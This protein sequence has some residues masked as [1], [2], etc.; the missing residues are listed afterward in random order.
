MIQKP[1]DLL[2]FISNIPVLSDGTIPLNTMN[3]SVSTMPSVYTPTFTLS[4]LARMTQDI[5]KNDEIEPVNTE[6][7]PKTIV[8]Q[9]LNSDLA[10]YAPSIYLLLRAVI[11]ESF[12]LLYHI[13]QSSANLQYVSTRDINKIK[14]NVNYIADFFGTEEKYYEMIEAMRDIHISYGYLQN[15]IDVIMRDKGVI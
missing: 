5:L 15:Q 14:E 7:N 1:A 6:L 9:A 3:D 10:S 2:R 13:E 4:T 8:S 11:L 12:S